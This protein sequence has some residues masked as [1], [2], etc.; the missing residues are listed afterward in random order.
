[1]RGNQRAMPIDALKSDE[2]SG[3]YGS[4]QRGIDFHIAPRHEGAFR[5]TWV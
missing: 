1:M 4:A 3:G 2:M 5:G